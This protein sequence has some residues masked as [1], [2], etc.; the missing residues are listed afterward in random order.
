MSR[1]LGGSQAMRSLSRF[2]DIGGPKTL[3]SLSFRIRVPQALGSL[4]RFPGLWFLKLWKVSPI[5]V[6]VVAAIVPLASYYR[7]LRRLPVVG[8]A[9]G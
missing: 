1:G 3:R 9:L 8:V 2:P 7:H 4:S 6:V 5:L